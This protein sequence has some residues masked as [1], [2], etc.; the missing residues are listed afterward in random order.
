MSDTCEVVRIVSAGH[1]AYGGFVEINKSDFD[2]TKHTL[3]EENE[4]AAPTTEDEF[5]SMSGDDLRAYLTAVNTPFRRNASDE[6]LRSL[7]RSSQ[8]E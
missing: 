7:C 1:K 6:S 3:W 2:A 8:H 4:T 5:S